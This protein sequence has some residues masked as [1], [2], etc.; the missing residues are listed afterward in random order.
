MEKRNILHTSAKVV[1]GGAAFG[2]A[3]A[4]IEL[5]ANLFGASIINHEYSP[6]R[7]FELAATLMTYVI[8]VLAWEILA[9]LKAGGS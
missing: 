8:A 9:E 6:G 4:F 3:I 7:I 2:M 1:F 5:A